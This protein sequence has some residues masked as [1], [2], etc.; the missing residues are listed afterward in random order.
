VFNDQAVLGAHHLR[1]GVSDRHALQMV[2]NNAFGALL[3]LG[4]KKKVNVRCGHSRVHQARQHSTARNNQTWRQWLQKIGEKRLQ[5]LQKHSPWDD[6]H[7][8]MPFPKKH[9]THGFLRFNPLKLVHFATRRVQR[10]DAV[11][12]IMHLSCETARSDRHHEK[13]I[14]ALRLKSSS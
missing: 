9:G 13:T 4:A 3:R 7:A 2:R 11:H 12:L 10:N 14:G 6:F 5:S 1:V 8:A